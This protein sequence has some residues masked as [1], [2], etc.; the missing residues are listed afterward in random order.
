MS[1]NRRN[2]QFNPRETRRVAMYDL[3]ISSPV[4]IRRLDVY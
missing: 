1:E 2:L 3:Q 4:M